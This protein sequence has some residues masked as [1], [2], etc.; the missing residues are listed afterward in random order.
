MIIGIV[1]IM[2]TTRAIPLQST[3]IE[4]FE[5]MLS[6]FVLLVLVLEGEW[7]SGTLY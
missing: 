7:G 5:K 6:S 1:G 2:T 4:R 3:T